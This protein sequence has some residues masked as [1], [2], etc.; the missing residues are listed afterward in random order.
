MNRKVTKDSWTHYPLHNPK[1]IAIDLH[2]T[3][4]QYGEL[5]KG[6]YPDTMNEHW[7]IYYDRGWLCFHCS[8]TGLGVFKAKL[9]KE[10]DGYSVKE[11]WSVWDSYMYDFE[12]DYRCINK[13]ISIIARRLLHISTKKF[14][15]EQK[16]LEDLLAAY[17]QLFDNYVDVMQATKLCDYTDAVHAT[18]VGVAVGD[19][20]GVPVEF[21]N[22]EYLHENPVTEMLG[23]ADTCWGQPAGTWSDDSSLT[24]CLAESLAKGFDLN[25]MANRFVQ[26]A[27]KDYWT[28]TGVRFDIGSTTFDAILRLEQGVQPELAGRTDERANGNGALM[29]IL[30]LV[31]YLLDKP[32]VER[33]EIT[34]RVA[35][36]TH[37]HIRSTIACFYYLE[38]A[39]NIFKRKSKR[40]IYRIL[41][42]EVSQH[43]A[44]L[45][46]D[47]T[48]IAHF[49]RLLKADISNLPEDAISSNGYVV[50]TLEAA[51]WSLMT[52]CSY[53]EA[54]LRAVNL[55]GDTDT[56]AAVVGGLA[57]LIY[58]IDNIPVHWLQP[59]ARREDIEN[60]AERL[61]AKISH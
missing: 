16:K 29:R 51:V 12:D 40:Q 43:L 57:G 55:G 59:L 2:F 19:A 7:F 17:T 32:I 36:I 34:R 52:T 54:V 18:L 61:A 14:I 5:V 46:L 10:T 11:F 9:L 41:Q 31:F 26:W 58:G 20:L 49:D 1:R 4:E 53:E 23:G 42:K 60:L 35:S 28:A 24:F 45:A 47:T 8:R 3:D 33:F 25:D 15:A 30:P 13:F 44:K 6:L 50:Y 38:F 48:E 56:T 27:T 22:R 21:K 39:R 37:G